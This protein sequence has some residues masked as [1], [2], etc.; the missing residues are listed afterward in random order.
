MRRTRKLPRTNHQPGP[1]GALWRVS[2]WRWK[3]KKA[4]D[5]GG[6]GEEIVVYDIEDREL[7]LA[8]A[9]MLIDRY[10]AEASPTLEVDVSFTGP[11]VASDAQKSGD[12]PSEAP[13]NRQPH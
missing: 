2:A 11:L 10:A 4:S 12:E 3:K 9:H 6:I 1:T 13:S 5:S 8:A 7:A